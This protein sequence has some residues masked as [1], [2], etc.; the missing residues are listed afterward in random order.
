MGLVAGLGTLAGAMATM[1]FG[2]MRPGALSFLFG[3]TTG[4]MTA[5]ILSDL[6]PSA[7]RYSSIKTVL[8]GFG[9]GAGLMYAIDL[10]LNNFPYSSPHSNKYL[11]IGCLIAAGIAV[12]DLPEGLAIAAAFETSEKLGS[13]LVLAIGLHNIPEGM[14]A[15]VPLRFGGLEVKQVVV[16]SALISLMTPLGVALGLVII[17]ISDNFIGFILAFAA[18]AMGYIVPVELI[19]ES[20]RQNRLAAGTGILAGLVSILALHSLFK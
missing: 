15:A 4:I 11:K 10:V 14:A 19:P 1:R 16:L 13:L 3:L 18:G 12:H 6:L 8:T 7:C 9:G 5:V 2:R 20:M 17:S